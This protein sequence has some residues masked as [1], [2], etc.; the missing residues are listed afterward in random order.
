MFEYDDKPI[1]L[2]SVTK[3]NSIGLDYKS[4]GLYADSNGNVCNM[5][6]YY[7]LSSNIL[8]KQQRKLRHKIQ[9]TE[10]RPYGQKRSPMSLKDNH[11]VDYGIRK[12]ATLVV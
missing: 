10:F 12:H 3:E 8:A 9:D 11:N 6:H 1:I 4:D 5:P 2:Q 7:R